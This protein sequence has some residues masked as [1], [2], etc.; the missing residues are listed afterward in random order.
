MANKKNKKKKNN[1]NNKNN[2][3][4][5]NTSQNNSNVKRDIEKT[6]KTDYNIPTISFKSGLL[7]MISA[8]IGTILVPYLFSMFGVDYRLGVIIGNVVITAFAVSYT[9]YFIETKRGFCIGF[10]RLYAIF[11]VAFAVIGWFW[12]YKGVYL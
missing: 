5:K 8:A 7:L 10:W 6:Q 12:V 1:N 3:I 2:H 11:A 4:K 9:R